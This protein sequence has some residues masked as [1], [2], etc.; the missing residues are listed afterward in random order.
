MGGW[1]A[2]WHSVNSGPHHA[3][4]PVFLQADLPS[5]TV[6]DAVAAIQAAWDKSNPAPQFVM[7]R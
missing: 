1:V 2:H 7:K 5:D 6:A 4:M 3:G